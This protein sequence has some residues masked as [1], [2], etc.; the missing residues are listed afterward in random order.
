MLS[1]RPRQHNRP[2]SGPAGPR[3]ILG[4]LIV[5]NSTTCA[6]AGQRVLCMHN[7]RM[8]PTRACLATSI[9]A[10]QG[11]SP[12]CNSR[13]DCDEI[14]RSPPYPV[15]SQPGLCRLHTLLA[16]AG[17][18]LRRASLQIW[19]EM[20]PEARGARPSPYCKHTATNPRDRQCALPH[21]L[22]FVRGSC[23]ASQPADR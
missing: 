20:A 14:V 16:S 22:P 12:R 9:S 23:A 21:Y 10:T 3:V 19:A 18:L 4:H 1:V 17:L 2:E 13:P 15:L 7:G 6:P 11:S 5:T 8:S